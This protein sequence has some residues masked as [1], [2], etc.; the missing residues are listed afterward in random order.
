M[1]TLL[2]KLAAA[3]ILLAWAVSFLI[4]NVGTLLGY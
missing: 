1:N 4:Y 3:W 2:K